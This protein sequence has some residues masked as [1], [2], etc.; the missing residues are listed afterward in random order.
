MK[1]IK[2]KKAF[3]LIEL[4]VT[5]TILAITAG[6][7]VGIFASAMSNYSK[8][9]MTAKEQALA[10]EIEDFIV[11]HA[12]ICTQLYLIDSTY[13]EDFSEEGYLA[14]NAAQVELEDSD[15]YILTL[16]PDTNVA[17]YRTNERQKT[18]DATG[19]PVYGDILDAPEL[20]VS[21]VESIEFS[22]L[23]QKLIMEDTKDKA[24]NYLQ[25]TINMQEGYSIT[26]AVML[27]SCKN[28]SY[29][30]ENSFMEYPEDG[31]L[32]L[33]GEGTTGINGIAFV[34]K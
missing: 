32:T 27:Y 24:F 6:F 14:A 30:Y 12:R 34:V 8:A 3:T 33:G 13:G 9:S 5:V 28:I 21:G 15:S 26:G 20:A 7:G 31:T 16:A 1:N 22:L 10:T 25:Y 19:A 17:R 18:E 4:I 29:Q 2:S 11:D 23:K